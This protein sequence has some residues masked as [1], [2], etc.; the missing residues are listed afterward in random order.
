MGTSHG[1]GVGRV[2]TECTNCW[3][4]AF[5]TLMRAVTPGTGGTRRNRWCA[6]CLDPEDLELDDRPG[7]DASLSYEDA[8][9]DPG[10][11]G[12]SAFE[13]W[14][15]DEVV[16]AEVGARCAATEC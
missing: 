9:I 14:C 1:C 4:C 10:V 6:S 7:L 11:P 2:D 8:L 16:V 15:R 5:S 12:V 3:T 13:A